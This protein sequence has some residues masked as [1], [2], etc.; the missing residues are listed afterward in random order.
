MPDIEV[1]I[2]QA[3]RENDWWICSS[4]EAL[5]VHKLLM[6]IKKSGK[7]EKIVYKNANDENVVL[8][9]SNEKD[10]VVYKESDPSVKRM[11]KAMHAPS[12]KGFES[13]KPSDVK[14][15]KKLSMSVSR[16]TRKITHKKSKSGGKRKSKSKSKRKH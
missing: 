8:E 7:K 4:N 14:K 2:K 11:V 16:K 6:A 1:C 5:N 10:I 13:G 12:H 9:G 3:N 15:S